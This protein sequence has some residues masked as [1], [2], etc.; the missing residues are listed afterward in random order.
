MV[1]LTDRCSSRCNLVVLFHSRVLSAFWRTKDV[2]ESH[3][4]ATAGSA[5]VVLKISQIILIN[6]LS[7]RCYFR[8]NRL[9][10]FEISFCW[11]CYK[12]NFRKTSEAIDNKSFTN[13]HKKSRAF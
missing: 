12:S 4:I 9:K 2:F 8:S 1:T 13:L 5:N 6:D 7:F 10:L 3:L 11:F